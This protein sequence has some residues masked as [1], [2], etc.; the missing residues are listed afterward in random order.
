MPPIDL[1][2]PGRHGRK[3]EGHDSLCIRDLPKENLI[4][5]QY[6]HIALWLHL[7]DEL[8]HYVIHPGAI[9]QILMITN[10]VMTVGYTNAKRRLKNPPNIFHQISHISRLI[11]WIPSRLY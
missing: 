8:V 3:R 4:L 10:N 5:M 2:R 9:A 1:E 7:L 11:A 6:I